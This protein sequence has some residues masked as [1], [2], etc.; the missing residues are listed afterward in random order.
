MSS[1]LLMNSSRRA[2]FIGIWP[3]PCSRS[4]DLRIAGRF[5]LGVIDHTD[6]A[7]LGSRRALKARA[8]RHSQRAQSFRTA[9]ID[10]SPIPTRSQVCG[11]RLGVPA[12]RGLCRPTAGAPE[13]HS[14]SPR[15]TLKNL[16]V[17]RSET[18]LILSA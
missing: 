6:R 4:F 17:L 2:L 14:R 1:F 15:N 12:A 16:P 3:W 7:G 13:R 9:L 8:I 10:A 18:R 5:N 11:D